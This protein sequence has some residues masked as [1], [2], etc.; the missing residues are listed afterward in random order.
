MT[1][2]NWDRVRD[3]KKLKG[4]SECNYYGGTS[5][6]DHE[7]SLDAVTLDIAQSKKKKR[8]LAK[9]A[10][11]T[12]AKA[13]ETEKAKIKANNKNRLK[14]L[15]KSHFQGGLNLNV[16]K[17]RSRTIEFEFN[18]LAEL[19]K[20][21]RIPKIKERAAM[22]AFRNWFNILQLNNG[23]TTL[24][25]SLCTTLKR[26]IKSKIFCDENK[27]ELNDMHQDLLSSKEQVEITQN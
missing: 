14:K 9:Q 6:S 25:A 8:K 12:K 13:Q 17:Y 7:G 21:N 23:L 20:Q 18:Y 11:R 10:A 16:K 4:G 19:L 5:I 22:I 3:D 2:L 1:N 15:K 24:H 26:V 27:S